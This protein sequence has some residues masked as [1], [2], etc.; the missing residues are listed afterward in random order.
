MKYKIT[1]LY[2]NFL[3]VLPSTQFKREWCGEEMQEPRSRKPQTLT[4]NLDSHA[5][6]APVSPSFSVANYSF[7]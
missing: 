6:V 5:S 7:T 2:Y 3:L 1:F 4:S